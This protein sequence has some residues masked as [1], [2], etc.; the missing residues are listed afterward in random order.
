MRLSD[1]PL[2]EFVMRHAK[3]EEVRQQKGDERVNYRRG[4]QA[5]TDGDLF[6]SGRI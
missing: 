6:G 1:C 4:R 2:R 5:A 3:L